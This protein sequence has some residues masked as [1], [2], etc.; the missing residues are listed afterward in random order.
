MND[1]ES[2]V[3]ELVDEFRRIGTAQMQD[4]PIY[5]PRLDVEAVGFQALGE[6]WI[7]VLI[8]PWFMSAILLPTVK[9]ALDPRLFGQKCQE[10]LP[11]ATYAFVNGGVET[12]GSYKSLPLHSPM[13]AFESQESARREAQARLSAL[14]TPPAESPEPAPATGD[15]PSPLPGDPSRRA[16][17][18]GHP[19]EMK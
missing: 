5:N 13:G 12:V 14:L 18:F 17:L 10:L 8:T 11:A 3:A 2:R 1:I 7:G 15:A 9:C 16:F 6:R 19:R 4:L